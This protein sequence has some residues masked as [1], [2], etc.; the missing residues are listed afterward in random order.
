[1]NIILLGPPGAGKGTQA[2][3]LTKKL[4][5]PHI[6]TGDMFRAAIS[7]GTAL[8]VEAKAYMDKGQL[9]PD[10]ITVGIIRDRIAQND[11]K[12]GFLLDGFPR[13]VV[14]AEALDE[15]LE[16]LGMNI[17]AVLNFSVPLDKLIVRLTGR[18]MCRGC[19][20]IY[21]QLYH[22]PQKEGICDSCG[23]ELY[24]RSDDK[25]ETV[26]NRLSVYEAQTAPLIDYYEA[27]GLLKTINGDQ[28][29]N[30]VMKALGAA[31]GQEW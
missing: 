14:Q 10:A 4:F 8:G 5:V 19:G 28:P 17:D 16:K 2:E 25:E 27:K 29:I 20:T 21:H 24:Q 13:T 30:E 23:S 12:G 3:V 31:L 22:A 18:R 11:C 1:M 9:V 6:S 15:L 26:K 7:N